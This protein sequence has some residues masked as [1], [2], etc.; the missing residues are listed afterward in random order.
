MSS[1]YSD[2][3]KLEL[4]ATGA[5]ANTWGNNTNT[6]LQV[7]DT[8][9]AGYLAKSVAGSANIT[10]TTGNADA[11]AE[12][13]NKVIEFTGALTGDI[14][15]FVPAVENNYVFF[16]NTSGSQTLSIAPTG[17]TSNAVAVTQGAH[18]IMYLSL[19]HI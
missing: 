12:A 14:I 17:H 15:V 19:I 18:T 7:V 1:T 3:L 13:A 11:S 4:M 9:T 16:N 6:N 5:N 8:F 2:R 10:L